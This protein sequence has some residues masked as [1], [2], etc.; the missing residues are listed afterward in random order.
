MDDLQS[1][2]A[3]QGL[4]PHGYCIAWSPGL[5][6]TL[7]SADALIAAAYYSIPLGL[8]VLARQRRDLAFHVR[9]VRVLEESGANL[10]REPLPQVLGASARRPKSGSRASPSSIL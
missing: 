4:L 9:P 6:W 8:F 7:V 3:G 1:F 10:R 2:L 5:L